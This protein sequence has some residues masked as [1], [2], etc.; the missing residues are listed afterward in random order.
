MVGVVMGVGAMSHVHKMPV[1][2]ASDEYLPH[3]VDGA[4]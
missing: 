4:V 1:G 3:G 2:R